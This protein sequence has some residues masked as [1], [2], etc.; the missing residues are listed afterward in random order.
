MVAR[1]CAA[2]RFRT[3]TPQI[4]RYKLSLPR[5]GTGRP[6]HFV[7]RKEISPVVAVRCGIPL[8]RL[9]DKG[10]LTDIQGRKRGFR[11]SVI[12]LTSNL[13]SGVAPKRRMGIGIEEEEDGRDAH[14]P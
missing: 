8:R 5:S 13:G 11:E 9:S 12:I 6:S 2:V 7:G 1:A 10:T 4:R 3:L 14:A